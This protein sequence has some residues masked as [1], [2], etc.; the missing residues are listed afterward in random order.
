VPAVHSGEYRDRDGFPRCTYCGSISAKE[1]MRRLQ[2][3]GESFSGTDKGPYK[4]YIGKD[5][6][7]FYGEHLAEFTNAELV[8]WAALSRKI[9]G[10]DVWRD[11]KGELRFVRPRS[12][13]FYGFQTFGEIGQDGK[14]VFGEGSPT[15][16]EESWFVRTPVPPPSKP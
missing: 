7:K 14:P 11:E 9:F 8:E 5:H 15:P 10:M 12:S 4:F 1:A 6:A 3:P 16:P 2:T 13:S